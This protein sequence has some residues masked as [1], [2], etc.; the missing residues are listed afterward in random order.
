MPPSSDGPGP[1]PPVFVFVFETCMIEEEFEFTKSAVKRG[2]GLVP[3]SALVGVC[4]MNWN[5]LILSKV[6]VFRGE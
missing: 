3:E 2:V 6:Y 4:F 5:F 1:L